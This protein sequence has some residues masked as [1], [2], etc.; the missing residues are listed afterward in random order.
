MADEFGRVGSTKDHSCGPGGLSIIQT[1]NHWQRDV[2]DSEADV[3]RADNIS[4]WTDRN[5][6]ND[7]VKKNSR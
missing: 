7:V 6:R 3:G 5:F 4:F 1:T 2:D